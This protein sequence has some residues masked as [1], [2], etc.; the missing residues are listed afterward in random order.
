MT[1]LRGTAGR[2]CLP[3]AAHCHGCAQLVS[4]LCDGTFDRHRTP[5]GDLCPASETWPR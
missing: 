5:A 1:H 4:L 2:E 3:E